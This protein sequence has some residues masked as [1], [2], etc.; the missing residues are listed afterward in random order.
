[1]DECAGKSRL[2][3]HVREKINGCRIW[4][5]GEGGT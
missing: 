2:L 4:I 3:P 1:M 5:G